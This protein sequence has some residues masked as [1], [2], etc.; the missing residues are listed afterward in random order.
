[1][2]DK[3]AFVALTSVAASGTMTVAKLVVGL[4]T[5]SLGILSEAIHSLLDLA[6]AIMTYFAVRI[7][8]QPA[9][10]HHH[11]GHGKVEALS[12]L[13]ATL[14]LVLTSFWIIWES[15]HRLLANSIEVEATW[16]AVVLVLVVIGVDISRSRALMKVAKE[17]GSQA[18]EADAMH[19]M[20]DIL[21]SAA[22]LIGLGLVWFGWPRG[23]AVAA[24]FVAVVVL[25]AAWHLGKSAVEVLIDTAPEGIAERVA[26][27]VKEFD[28]IISVKYVRV[29]PA[30]PVIF[31]EI[32]IRV[33]RTLSLE[34]VQR[35]RDSISVRLREEM[36]TIDVRVDAEPIVLDDESVNE[37]V[38]AVAA[39]RNLSVHDIDLRQASGRKYLSFDVELDEDLPIREAH[40]IATALEQDLIRDL[41]HD[42][43]VT[44]HIDPRRTQV[45]AGRNLSEDEAAPIAGAITNI[46]STIVHA[47]NIHHVRVAANDDGLHIAFHCTFDPDLPLRDAHHG[48]ALLEQAVL[49]GVAG[50]VRVVVHAEP[51]EHFEERKTKPNKPEKII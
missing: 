48:A 41:G 9:D 35:L 42:V 17:T 44:T 10:E 25:A 43:E 45:S 22:V 36:P 33:S 29:R 38:R 14:L 46:A 20:S 40:D 27:V 5:G 31:A 11:Y 23:D 51:T 24:L 7:S 30:G 49:R 13:F 34:N 50:T 4:L 8:D 3:K 26:A 2:V 6:S 15:I 19:Y 28:S 32:L 39:A 21:S 12:A 1:M 18:L 37:T 16:Y 47:R